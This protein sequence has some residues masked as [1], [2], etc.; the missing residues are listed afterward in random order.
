[1][2]ECPE[3]GVRYNESKVASCPVCRGRNAGKGNAQASSGDPVR[4]T[5]GELLAERK[6]Q[7]EQLRAIRWGVFGIL[8]VIV[9]VLGALL[10]SNISSGESEFEKFCRNEMGGTVV[11]GTCRFPL[12]N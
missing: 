11:G 10:I 1:M 12:R 6:R 7:S 4:D 5:N 3:C 2:I 9:L 8:G